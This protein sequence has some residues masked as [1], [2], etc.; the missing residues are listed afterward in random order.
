MYSEQYRRLGARIC[1]YRM[2]SNTSQED[3]ANKAGISQ[4]YLSRIEHGSAGKS[5][6][7]TTVLAI[8]EALKVDVVELV[9]KE[10]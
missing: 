4:S 6:S 9:K 8:A 10:I 1:Y 2:L 3:L 5:V 7:Y